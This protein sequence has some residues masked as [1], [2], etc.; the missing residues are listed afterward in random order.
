MWRGEANEYTNTPIYIKRERERENK[1][2]GERETERGI[3]PKNRAPNPGMAAQSAAMSSELNSPKRRM[4]HRATR[5]EVKYDALPWGGLHTKP[6]LVEQAGAMV[7]QA[8]R[9]LLK[10]SC[11][12]GS[13]RMTQRDEDPDMPR[14]RAS[15]RSLFC[16]EAPQ[17]LFD[18]VYQLRQLR[19][20]VKIDAS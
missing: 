11:P 10:I 7:M 18:R 15:S 20:L 6:A 8:R 12:V 5:D 14:P 9:L 13:A 3:H 4:G 16:Q 19:S 1:N 17:F 2:K